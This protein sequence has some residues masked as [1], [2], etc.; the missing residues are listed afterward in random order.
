MN[1]LIISH[2]Y[3]FDH[4]GHPLGMNGTKI[5]VLKKARQI[6]LGSFLKRGHGA[7]LETEILFHFLGNLPHQALKGKLAEQ[8]IA[9]LRK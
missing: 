9:R 1:C 4:D 3:I 7:G 8:K 2:A 5:T 6:G